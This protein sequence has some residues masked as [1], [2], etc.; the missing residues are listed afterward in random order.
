MTREEIESKIAVFK[1]SI[2]TLKLE[3]ETHRFHVNSLQLKAMRKRRASLNLKLK[4]WKAK[5]KLY[6]HE[7]LSF[8]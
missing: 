6:P 7:T 8:K 1:A 4:Y 2:D 3:I 5:L